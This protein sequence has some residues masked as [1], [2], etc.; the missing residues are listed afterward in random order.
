MGKHAGNSETWIE[1]RAA[2]NRGKGMSPRHAR[3]GR[4]AR[5]SLYARR[6]LARAYGKV[7]AAVA[8]Q[9]PQTLAYGMA[10]A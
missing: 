3:G 1:A 6:A 8:I 7:T 4:H 10:S 9:A 5:P 2:I